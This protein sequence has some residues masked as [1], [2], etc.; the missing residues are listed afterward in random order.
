MARKVYIENMPLDQ[1]LQLVMDRLIKKD[2]FRVQKEEIE[3]RQALGRITAE[4]VRARKSSPHYPASAMDG[5]A[6]RSR[7][8]RGASETSPVLLR[9][10]QQ[11]VELD[12]GDP[13][14]REFDAVIMIEDVNYQDEN[15]AEIIVPAVPWQHVRSVGEDLIASQMIV[16]ALFPVGPFEIGSLLTAGV[17]R[18]K[19]V[20]KPRVAIIPTGTEIVEPGQET[21]QAGEITESNSRMLAGLCEQ[22]GALPLRRPIAPDDREVLREAIRQA[23]READIIVVCSGSSAG[24]EDYTA[25]VI[26]ELGELIL[27]GLATR[28]GKPAIVG[29]LGQKPILGV[30]GYPVSA[31]LVFELIG[32]PLIFALQGV[33]PPESVT[34]EAR[35]AR[36]LASSMGV[37]EFV[38]VNLARVGTGYLAFPR[39]RGAG[40]TSSLVKSDGVLVIPR[41]LEGYQPG[42]RVSIHL[43]RPLEVVDRTILAIG[44]HDLALDYLGNLLWKK[45]RLRLA[46]TNVGSMGGIMAL[47]RKETHLAGI[48]LL[49]TE[50]GEYNISYLL[51]Y[52]KGE[53]LILMNLVTREQGLMVKPGNPLGIKG[54]EDLAR[55]EVRFV[56]RQKGAGTRIL[57]DY[58]LKTGGLSPGQINGYEREEYSHLA[59]AAAVSNDTA[60]VSLGIYASC[61]ALG[62]DFIPVASE[63]YDM[64]ILKD[65]VDGPILEAMGQVIADPEFSAETL[66]FGGY[67][68]NFSGQVMWESGS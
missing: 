30:P 40:A 21:M 57:L 3:V 49:D 32:R 11:F 53:N 17:T 51:R 10:D 58:L 60:D 23:A 14:P 24:R 46:S 37:D 36:K 5:I 20:R 39:N 62:L 68:L 15:T 28:P 12:T 35:L 18:I 27:H 16:P 26:S 47:K 38:H 48:H 42:D 31:A 9:R 7:D 66:S 1:A 56:N 29:A 13:V 54:L 55:P 8:T 59:V 25:E 19:V 65:L 67:D 41:G 50:T 45:H 34:L 61:K 52:L 2:G 43:T 63:R 33:E 44:S 22:W 6:V 4:P 64:C